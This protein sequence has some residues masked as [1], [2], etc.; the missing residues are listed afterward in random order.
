METDDSHGTTYSVSFRVQRVTVEYAFVKVPV[1][2]DLIVAQSDGTGRIDVT[3]MVQRAIELGQ[4][5]SLKWYEED[6]QI[7]PH[8]IQKAPESDEG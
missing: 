5:P 6:K 4:S 1:T 7:Q 3:K 8:P 2:S